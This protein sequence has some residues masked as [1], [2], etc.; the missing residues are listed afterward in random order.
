MQILR[1]ISGPA[2]FLSIALMVS[3]SPVTAQVYRYVDQNGKVHY[4]E[5]PP[6]ENAGRAVDKLSGQ[7]VVVKRIGAAPTAEERAAEAQAKKKK[8]EDEAVQRVEQRKIQAIMSA[9]SSEQDLEAA[10]MGA[11]N[12]VLEVITQTEGALANNAKRLEDLKPEVDSFAGKVLPGKLRNSVRGLENEQT[13]LKQL[14]EAKRA[15]E[16]AINARFDEDRRRY[17]E[18]AKELAAVRASR[19]SAV[20]TSANAA[21]K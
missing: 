2:A 14:L 12:P 21:A 8:A 17:I 18:G 1:S 5:R 13:A 16:L 4:T 19:K 10:R 20:P 7:G 15:Q 11:L 6:A 3:A 9:Y